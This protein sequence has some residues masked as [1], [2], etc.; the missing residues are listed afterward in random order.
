MSK[1]SVFGRLLVQNAHSTSERKIQAEIVQFLRQVGYFVVVTSANTPQANGIAGMTDLLA[2]KHDSVLL[3]ECKSAT[4]NLRPSQQAFYAA[5]AA[6]LGQHVQ[7][8]V[9][10]SLDDVLPVIGAK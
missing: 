2:F 7:Y 4:G 6:H 10:R 5:I 1:K 9:A 3:I 8:V